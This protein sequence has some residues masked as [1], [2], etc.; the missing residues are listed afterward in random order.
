MPISTRDLS[1][2]PDP[3]PLEK[4]T[5]S[6][7]LLEAIISPVWEYRYFSYNRLWDETKGERMASMRNGSGD[8][9][10]LV[11]SPLGAFLKGF[12][13]ESP[14]SPWAQEPSAVWPGVLDHVPAKFAPFL[15]E[16]A[17]SAENTTFCIWKAATD[18]TWQ[19]GPV[20][21]PDGDDPDGS[22][23]LLWMLDGNPETY[24]QFATEHYEET[25]NLDQIRKIYEWTPLHSAIILELKP[26]ADIGQ[27]LA[28]AAEIGYPVA[29]P[30]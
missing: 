14:M 16:P 1:A 24:A 25:L 21:F 10:F 19:R 8:E 23:N 5:Q 9:Y 4:L 30:L 12:D 13:H 26:E 20:S 22:E 28:D 7:A 29:N 18:P 17:F 2:L 3:H 15:P 11:F 6:I 27:A